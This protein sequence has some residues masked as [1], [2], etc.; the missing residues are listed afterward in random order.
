M[1]LSTY[2]SV[3]VVC[4]LIVTVLLYFPGL[5]GG[6]IFDD[7]A[8]IVKN[9]KLHIQ[10]L[11][12]DSLRS[13]TLSGTAGPLKRPVSMLSFA[14]NYFFTGMDPFAFKAVNLL[15]HLLNGIAVYLVCLLTLRAY[16]LLYDRDVT[17]SGIRVV[18]LL[19]ATAWLVHPINVTSVLYVVQR[20]NSLAAL[21]TLFGLAAYLSLRLKLLDGKRVFPLLIAS[22]L[23]FTVAGSLCKENGALLP[24]FM[25]V[26]EV[27]I[28]RFRTY[29]NSRSRHLKL[30]FLIVVAL[31]GALA[32]AYLATHTQWLLAGYEH[33]EFTLTERLLTEARILWFYLSQI[34]LPINTQLGLFHDDIVTSTGISTPFTTLPALAGIAIMAL[35]IYFFRKRAPLFSLGL[36]IFLTG[37]SLESSIFP[38]ELAHE[39]RNYVPALGILLPLFFYMNSAAGKLMT[40]R[41]AS[42][43]PFLFIALFSATTLLRAMDW[44][45]PGR[46]YLMEVAHHPDSSRANYE[47]GVIYLHIAEANPAI[48]TEYTNK[49]RPH[50][51]TAT[52]LRSEFTDGLFALIQID[53]R[54]NTD[55]SSDM[56]EEL[57]YRLET[58]PYNSNNLNW[59]NLFT[60]CTPVPAC[61]PPDA[62][63]QRIFSASIKN[64]AVTGH[65]RA[66]IHTMASKYTLEELHDRRQALQ[67][68]LAAR[69]SA[70]ND[71]R[72]ELHL[73]TMFA[74]MGEMEKARTSLE[75]AE[76]H[77]T[78][79]QYKV[80]IQQLRN[81][82]M[83]ASGTT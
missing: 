14:L 67:L 45:N 31:P 79:G 34:L 62:V 52:E 10:T 19:T 53:N 17:D 71:P 51:I 76:K 70:P 20:M 57:A 39:H 75:V 48:K 50:F 35:S 42:L 83:L 40:A 72:Y 22:S 54:S 63:M 81:Q 7:E 46:L 74:L 65:T 82:I 78:L 61:H 33:R 9:E 13:A 4:A 60:S 30:F 11:D 26:F 24:V 58:F 16:R 6:F 49:A 18:A 80:R 73:S 43:V 41:T 27:F 12:S 2:Q 8:N 5:S 25:L 32:M 21:F 44:G 59:I 68:I 37:H 15:I 69:A 38:L 55:I 29:E 3:L 23:F 56:I 47:L 1:K 77:D 66:E 28:F 64:T 36:A